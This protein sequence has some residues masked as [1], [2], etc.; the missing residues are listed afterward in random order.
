MVYIIEIIETLMNFGLTRQE[1][2]IYVLLLSEGELNGYEVSKITG[3]SRSNA[4]SCLASIVEKGGAY[5]IEG[6]AVKYTPVSVDEFCQNK[7]RTLQRSKEELIKNMPGRR[8]ESDGYITIKSE[9]HIIDKV[10]NMILDA[11]ERVYLSIGSQRL[12]QIKDEL[13]VLKERDIKVVIITDKNI[14]F[15][16]AQVYYTSKNPDQIGIIVDSK[17]VL[18]GDIK[19]KKTS[20]CL[21]SGNNNLV[22]VFKQSL[23]NEIKL[24]EINKEKGE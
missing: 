15:N 9:K 14:D 10:K 4:Y 6:S 22:E 20:T 12:V 17:Y 16:Y 23:T 21:Y 18:T 7:I 8:D 11:K 13:K 5:I 2:N 3:I 24:I 19:D 1:A